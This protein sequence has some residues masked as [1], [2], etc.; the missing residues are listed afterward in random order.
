[1]ARRPDPQVV[2]TFDHLFET[3]FGDLDVVPYPYGPNGKA[4]HFDYERLNARTVTITT[5]GVP[6][7]V[8]GLDDL[9]ASKL[10][11]RRA[12][13]LAAWPQLQGSSHLTAHATP[14]FI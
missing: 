7:R 3:A 12:K 6:V 10:L 8:A 14:T 1:M 4:D 9:V 5:F 11:R 2:E 13:G